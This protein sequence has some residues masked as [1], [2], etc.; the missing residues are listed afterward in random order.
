MPAATL[1]YFVVEVELSPLPAGASVAAVTTVAAIATLTAIGISFAVGTPA[2]I[3]A[4]T[5][6]TAITS[7]STLTARTS[8][9][10][11]LDPTAVFLDFNTN[12]PAIAAACT[13]SSVRARA[14]F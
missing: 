10:V 3:T 13:R 12:G 11:Y 2:A 6:L 14:A 5:T 9:T 4:L 8:A 7:L 1:I